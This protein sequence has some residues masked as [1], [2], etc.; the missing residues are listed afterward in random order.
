M[1]YLCH[2]SVER[3]IHAID[4]DPGGLWDIAVTQAR[5]CDMT[6]TQSEKIK[7]QNKYFP[8]TGFLDLMVTV[9]ISGCLTRVRSRLDRRSSDLLVREAVVRLA[10]ETD[11]DRHS[12]DLLVGQAFVRLA[13]EMGFYPTCWSRKPRNRENK[14][15]E[16]EESRKPGNFSVNSF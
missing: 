10:G 13:G 14:D 11:S 2:L 4:S 5:V 7:W 12:S 8:G 16:I 9:Q 15:L 3:G 1:L 6:V